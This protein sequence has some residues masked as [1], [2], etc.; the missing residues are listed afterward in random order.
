HREAMYY[1]YSRDYGKAAESMGKIIGFYEDANAQ[2]QLFSI[3]SFY[4][5]VLEKLDDPS[6]RK[7]LSTLREKVKLIKVS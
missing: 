4:I 7:L 6:S 2:S 1:Y 3:Y 5:K